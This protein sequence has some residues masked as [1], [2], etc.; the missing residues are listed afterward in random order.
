M[1]LFLDQ[2]FKYGLLV[3]ILEELEFAYV[4]GP[5]TRPPLGST[6]DSYLTSNGRG[7]VGKINESFYVLEWENVS[8]SSLKTANGWETN[9]GL[10]WTMEK[11]VVP[12]YLVITTS[13]R[14]VND[15]FDISLTTEQEAIYTANDAPYMVNEISYEITEVEPD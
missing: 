5:G 7:K 4:I 9:N 14:T 6:I 3:D 12:T 2:S 10:N 8:A 15:V 11:G 1:Q 13:T